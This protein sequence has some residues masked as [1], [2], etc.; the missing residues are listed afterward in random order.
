MTRHHWWLGIGA[1][2]LFLTGCA[3]TPDYVYHYVP[4]KTAVQQERF[5]IA[6]PGAPV[7]VQEMI[8]AG[9]RI[10]GSPYR[11]G[12]GHGETLAV[13]AYD[14]SGA[15]SYL[16]ISAG[17]LEASMPSSAFRKYGKPGPGKWISIYAAHGHV[18]AV[19]AGLRFDTGWAPG[20]QGPKWTTRTR[21][22][23][24]YVI[25]HPPGW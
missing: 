7:T 9:N 23:S 3:S 5:A 20:P 15:V 18:F 11:M 21:P 14:C 8:A 25:R 10:A 24:D 2:V 13:E 12:G 6:P 17:L 16:L 4:G 1:A 19:V 22:A